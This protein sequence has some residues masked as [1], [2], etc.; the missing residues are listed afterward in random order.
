MRAEL[1]RAQPISRGE[2][3]MA[4]LGCDRGTL[5]GARAEIGVRYVEQ[6]RMVMGKERMLPVPQLLELFGVLVPRG[7][8]GG[9]PAP[10]HPP[11]TREK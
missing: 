7:G 4:L 2:V 11:C 9:G 6:P 5:H 1:G 3:G 8:C 10:T